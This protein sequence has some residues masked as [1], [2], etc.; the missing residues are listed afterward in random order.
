MQSED[1]NTFM[2]HLAPGERLLWAGRPDPS[3][4]FAPGDVILLAVFSAPFAISVVACTFLASFIL[5]HW[6]TE[7]LLFLG[8]C[9]VFMGVSGYL[10]LGR[11]GY[12]WWR[13]RHTRY[14]LTDRRALVHSHLLRLHVR[15][16]PLSNLHPPR[17]EALRRDG[18]GSIVF[19][20]YRPFISWGENAGFGW[21]LGLYGS[22]FP[23]FFDIP[24]ARRVHDVASSI[25]WEAR[26]M[27]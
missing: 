18:R 12:K 6:Q 19:G 24:D 4:L 22:N 9:V 5:E 17:L 15:T 1:A 10:C 14:A 16:Y 13:K 2:A 3:I 11:I 21:G 20:P 25:V 27:G 7:T 8:L 26:T 23:A